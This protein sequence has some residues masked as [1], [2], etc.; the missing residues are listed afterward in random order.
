MAARR[1]KTQDAKQT[2]VAKDAGEVIKA[3]KREKTQKE[4]I[5]EHLPPLLLTY[6]VLICSGAFLMFSMRDAVAT[7]KNI[8]GSWDEAMLVSVTFLFLYA[9]ETVPIVSF[10]FSSH[11][12]LP[13]RPTGTTSR[14]DGSRHREVLVLSNSSLPTETIWEDYSSGSSLEPPL[15]VCTHKSSFRS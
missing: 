1:G 3:P 6:V 11:S 5:D 4:V 8:A 9:L 12:S 13:S 2:K 7:G 14:R 15:L 10:V